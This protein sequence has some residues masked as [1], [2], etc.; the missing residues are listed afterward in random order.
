MNAVPVVSEAAHGM[1]ARW[2]AGCRCTSAG[3][4]TAT[5]NEPGR[6]RAQQRLPVEMRQ[7]LL[8]AIYAGQ[9]FR[10]VLSDLGLTPGR[11]G[12]TREAISPGR[13]WCRPARAPGKHVIALAAARV[14]LH[15][16][17]AL[18][19]PVRREGA[20]QRRRR[21]R[22]K[23]RCSIRMGSFSAIYRMRRPFLGAVLRT[24]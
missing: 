16:V 17:V 22:C 13:P 8:D 19:L 3:E 1:S 11:A 2:H 6:A 18:M 15:H 14:R 23:S 9:Q 24:E 10:T 4:R 7:Q 12:P 5:P 20:T 21:N